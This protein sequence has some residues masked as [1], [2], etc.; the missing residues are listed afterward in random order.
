M[1]AV[2]GGQECLSEIN[3]NPKE[4]SCFGVAWNVFHPYIKRQ[5]SKTTHIL[6]TFFG[7]RGTEKDPAVVLLSPNNIRGTKIAFLTP[8]RY[9]G[10]P[11]SFL[12]RIPPTP[13]PRAG[14]RQRKLLS[15]KKVRYFSKTWS[16]TGFDECYDFAQLILELQIGWGLGTTTF[17]YFVSVISYLLVVWT[18]IFYR[19]GKVYALLGNDNERSY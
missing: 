18:L 2:R 17:D 9:D 14:W 19:N 8:K 12:Y 11:P 5:H 7:L 1:G 4:A 6:L 13:L 15:V 16:L 3:K 10:H